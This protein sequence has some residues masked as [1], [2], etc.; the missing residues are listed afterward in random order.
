MA[1][2]NCK[3]TGTGGQYFTAVF[4][5]LF[6]LTMLTVGFYGPWAWVRIYRLR[7]S[8]TVV[9]GK[10]VAFIGTGGQLFVLVVTQGMLTLITLGVYG[11]WALCRFFAW[12]AQNTLVGNRPSYFVG[13]GG[14]LFGF[15][16]LHGLLLP[17]I[18]LGLY[19]IYAPYRLCAWKEERTQYGGQRTS[20]APG[21]W[22]F[23][24][25]LLVGGFLN[26]V[27]L[28]FFAPWAMCMLY[29]WQTSR[30]VV[31]DS[32]KVEHFPPVKMTPLGT[33]VLVIIFLLN[34]VAFRGLIQIAVE[35]GWERVPW[36]RE[37][38]TSAGQGEFE[39]PKIRRSVE[40]PPR[41]VSSDSSQKPAEEKPVDA[42]PRTPPSSLSNKSRGMTA[43]EI[44]EQIS[45]LNNTIQENSRD[46]GAFY[47]RA[48]LYA[49]LGEL[50]EAISDYSRAIELRNT[51]TD[52]HYNRGLVYVQLNQL[53]LA[54]R[55]F[56]ATIRMDPRSGDAYCNR[57]NIYYAMGKA[58]LALDDYERALKIQ[59]DDP[60]LYYNRAIAL[61]S[62]GDKDRAD[63]DFKRAAK[64][65]HKKARKR[66]GLQSEVSPGT[67]ADPPTAV[68]GWTRN[69]EGVNAPESIAR[70]LIH[71]EE[72][73]AERAT[74]KDRVL[75]LRDGQGFFPDHALMIFLF[76]DETEELEGK[77][78]HFQGSGEI[79]W[80][81][82]H[83]KWKPHAS[84]VP[85][86]R[87]FMKDYVMRLDFGK[88]AQGMLPGKIYVCLPDEKKSFAAGT[89]AA[90]IR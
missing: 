86:T 76:V 18:T 84:R 83:M 34:I 21:F 12:R 51:Y 10:R 6:L 88:A 61:L 45:T 80:P 31:G 48:W 63:A 33:V 13:K 3:F 47:R 85:E 14:D 38:R 70:G 11:P 79:R 44:R 30:L 56:E 59:T 22:G 57:G 68:V 42:A 82:V 39:V 4:V 9:H 23:V 73:I 8:H 19:Y 37:F 55:D 7:A 69:L 46:A 90:V 29:R 54:L 74:L 43:A 87:I 16:L 60:D 65:G 5:R 89:F 27:T 50:Q 81:H 52:A 32:R 75:T 17:L 78:Y 25:V 15:L 72:F 20:F 26:T 2:G 71:G 24:K 58:Q 36:L 28:N 1:R 41:P 40:K 53:D 62:V 35:A 77:S 64:M 66:L 67:N 49:A